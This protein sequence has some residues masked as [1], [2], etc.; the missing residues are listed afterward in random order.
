M[1]VELQPEQWVCQAV[2]IGEKPK[3]DVRTAGYFCFRQ[4][5]NRNESADC[6]EIV[7][8]GSANLVQEAT[9]RADAEV[10]ASRG[11]WLA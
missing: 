10:K 8:T 7:F 9:R 4:N 2:T 5:T 6:E 11:F 1:C 3:V